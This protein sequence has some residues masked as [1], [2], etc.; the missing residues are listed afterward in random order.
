MLSP[1]DFCVLWFFRLGDL[2]AVCFFDE[3][4]GSSGGRDKLEIVQIS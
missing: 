3:A 4:A 1:A 2:I